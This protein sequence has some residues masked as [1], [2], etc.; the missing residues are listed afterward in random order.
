MEGTYC[1]HVDH[2][3]NIGRVPVI[4]S[5]TPGVLSFLRVFLG[6]VPFQIKPK[7]ASTST[8]QARTKRVW[9]LGK[10]SWGLPGSVVFPRLT[11]VRGSLGGLWWARSLDPAQ[12][13]G[14]LCCGSSKVVKT[15][16]VPEN[17]FDTSQRRPRDRQRRLE[18]WASLGQLRNALQVTPETGRR[19]QIRTSAWE[20]RAACFAQR[21]RGGRRKPKK[22]LGWVHV[23][24]AWLG[25]AHLAVG[26]N[27][28]Y[29]L[30][31]GEHWGY[32][33]SGF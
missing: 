15:A 32:G 25:F 27:Q 7:G 11:N 17:G 10:A 12:G 26:Q 1:T 28:W 29:H 18:P 31:V 4:S 30:G 16:G 2:Y 24:S 8:S 5:R 13:G 21:K 3:L 9:T 14:V 22:T 19:H 33:L 20:A 6:G 23:G